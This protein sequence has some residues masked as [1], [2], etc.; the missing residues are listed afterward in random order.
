MS[1]E[2]RFTYEYQ[3]NKFRLMRGSW[4]LRNGACEITG[5]IADSERLILPDSYR[6]NPVVQWDMCNEKETFPAVRFLSVPV[7]MTSINITNRLFPN[8]ERV[9]VQSGN[10]KYSTDGQMLLSAD[11]S[12]LL[13]SLAAGN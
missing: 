8:L 11:G 12:E 7:G 4:H 5:I 6:G 13:Y 9:E 10:S 1:R 2:E 3:G